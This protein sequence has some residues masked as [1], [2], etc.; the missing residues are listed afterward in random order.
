MRHPTLIAGHRGGL[1][2]WPENSA[3][4]FR[5]AARLPIDQAECDVHLTAD[6]GLVVHHDATLDRTTDAAGPVR[7]RR[8]EELRAVRVRGTE[9]EAPPTLAEYLGILA[10]TPVAPRIEIKAD[11]D[12][13]PYPGIVPAVM[14]ALDA[15]GQ[16]RRA[17]IIGFQRDTMAEAL[18]AGGLAG[19]SWLLELS[20]LA[21]IGVEGAI[22]VARECGFQEIGLHE[23]ALDGGMLARF[24]AAGLGVNVWGAN[25][26]SAIR[27]ML[28]LRVDL[29]ATDDPPL[30][31]R[32][33]DEA[34]V[35][36]SM[37]RPAT[38]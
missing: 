31:I 2:L 1:F 4:G 11:A 14:A 15:A 22:A 36:A 24:R 13:R 8:L 30:A 25:H 3:R 34:S 26:A 32:L 5:E 10:P 7:A 18:A 37:E 27:R 20:T 17:W 9:G 23:R 21:D 6:G 19:V 12:R 35:S 33:R 16:R 28:D 38:M 29:L